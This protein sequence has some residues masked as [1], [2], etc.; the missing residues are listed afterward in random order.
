MDLRITDGTT[1]VN[2][3]ATDAA[4][5]HYV[6]ATPEL[7]ITTDEG[8]G[9]GQEVTGAP[10]RNVTERADVLIEGTLTAAR[11]RL[12][13]LHRLMQTARQRQVRK[14]GPR[15]WVWYRLANTDLWYRSEIL[16]GRVLHDESDSAYD[17]QL[18]IAQ[19]EVSILWTRRPFWEYAATAGGV[20]THL[21]VFMNGVTTPVAITNDAG[22]TLDIDGDDLLGDLPAPAR[23]QITNTNDSAVNRHARVWVARNRHSAP[24]S[25]SHHVG[26]FTTGNSAPTETLIHTHTLTS[27]SLSHL[28][29][30]TAR[31]LG[32]MSSYW[33]NT[34]WL[35][36]KVYWLLT[37]LWEGPWMQQIGLGIKDM[38]AVALPPRPIVGGGDAAAMELRL[39]ARDPVNVTPYT[40]T[41]MQLLPVDSWRPLIPAGYG[42][43]ENW[44]LVD[45]PIEDEVYVDQGAVHSVHYSGRGGP[46][47]LTPGADQRLYVV[48]D[49]QT[50]ASVTGRTST[51]QAFY[52]P[53]RLTL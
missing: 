40:F 23:L 19:I 25:Y 46:V 31:I 16:A 24:A 45:D 11:A 44:T 39:Y 52:R 22:N 4:L 26:G 30:N 38:G 37:M 34:L 1:T 48:H 53:R 5:R 20:T 42:L 49:T 9:D 33:P 27:A 28:A 13:A 6:P 43:L 36:W 21:P 51:V 17:T 2:L 47:M 15:V 35:R 41:W 12:G 32:L 8:M 18:A 7:D 50:G 10:Y 3:T 14:L 29:G